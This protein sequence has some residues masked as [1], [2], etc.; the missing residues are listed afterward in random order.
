M[1][2][3]LKQIS[4]TVGSYISMEEIKDKDLALRRA[5][6]SGKL[7][8]WATAKLERNRVGRLVEQVKS[9]FL[10]EQQEELTDDPK[11]FWRLIKTIVPGKKSGRNKIT[12]LDKERDPEG[13]EVECANT[14]DFINSF[15]SSIGPRVGKETQRTMGTL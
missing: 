6:H 8:D 2:D 3:L 9:D 12:L 5:R 1:A 13:V 15:F 10:R 4:L 14:A 11:K 7:E